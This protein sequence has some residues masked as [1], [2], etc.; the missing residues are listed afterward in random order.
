MLGTSW[1]VICKEVVNERSR[2]RTE[3]EQQFLALLII[4]FKDTVKWSQHRN[5]K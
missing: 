4:I 3:K 1:E 5:E 2:G